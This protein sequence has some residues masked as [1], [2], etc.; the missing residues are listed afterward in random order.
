MYKTILVHV[1]L[2]AHAPARIHLA[3]VL[4]RAHDARLVGAAMLGISRHVF[5]NGFDTAP[6]TLAA[7]VFDPLAENARRALDQFER[8]A[9]AAGVRHASRFVADQADDGL[10][11]LARFADLVV[12]S[13]DDPRESM[14]DMAV[15]LQ[16]YVILNSARPVL[17]VPRGGAARLDANALV[18]WNGSKEAS[19]ALAAAIPLLAG[20]PRV[21][22]VALARAAEEAAFRDQAPDLLGFLR[23]HGV[24]ADMLV[25]APVRDGGH[26]LLAIARE[27][28]CGLL[29]MGCFGRTRFQELCLG[30]ASRTILASAGIPVLLAH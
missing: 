10:A 20:A 17:M 18:A 1:D 19:A 29:V 13:Q 11:R 30:G 3:A 9:D 6:G 7:G 24:E 5:P 28:G 27:F 12:V 26:D 21:T 8:I 22:V 4:A 2:S 14:P 15:H 25:R 23:G 16:E